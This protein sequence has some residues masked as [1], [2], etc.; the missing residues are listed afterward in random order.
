M[1]YKNAVL[2][3]DLTKNASR[4]KLFALA[5]IAVLAFGMLAAFAH[6]SLTPTV[7]LLPTGDGD[8]VTVNVTGD[9]SE[10]VELFYV[11]SGYGSQI[12]FLGDTNVNGI[13]SATL[14]SSADGIITGTPV[15][16][17]VGGINGTPSATTNWPVVST[18]LTGTITLSPTSMVVNVGQTATVGVTSGVSGSLYISNNSNP[19]VA[20]VSVSGSVVSVTGLA[21]GSTTVT[22][23]SLSSTS[24]CP[25]LYIRVQSAGTPTLSFSQSTLTVASG[26]TVPVTV[27]GGNGVYTILNN[28]NSG[29]I[30]A[31][32]AGS[33]VTIGTTAS[34]GTAAITVCSSDLTSCGII[35][36]TAG[37]T[38]SGVIT[39]SQQYPTLTIG[40]TTTVAVYGGSGSYYISSNSNPNIVGASVLNSVLTLTGLTSGSSAVSVCS[41]TGGCATLSATT[42]YTS[43]GGSLTLSQNTL[44]LLSG[45]TLSI[46]ISGGQAPYS[47]TT[48]STA[49]YQASISGNVLSVTGLSSGS[50]QMAVCSSAGGCTWLTLQINGSTVGTGGTLALSQ[51]SISLSAGQTS[52]ISISGTGG[53]YVS[54]VSTPTVAT[55]S[56]SGSLLQ[57]TGESYGSSTISVCQSGGACTTVYVSVGTSTTTTSSYGPAALLSF[58]TPIETIGLGQTTTVPIV[59]GSGIYYVAYSSNSGAVTASIAGN[60]LSLSGLQANS[61]DVVTVCSST[62][63]CGALPVAVGVVSTVGSTTTTGTTSVTT[64]TS[65]SSSD[66]YV[67]TQFLN[68]GSQGNEVVELQK[69][70][71]QLG[72]F[73]GNDTGYFGA[74][75]A[76]A[77]EAFQS[78]HGISAVGYVGPSTRAALNQ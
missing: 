77:V 73:S 43:S 58:G 63:S 29:I 30:F 61:L 49:M 74:L 10:A 23:C 26:Q 25:S 72:Y 78:A 52:S 38:S 50:T 51:T 35:N 11:K 68:V 17:A 54:N 67:F 21:F 20:N 70:L 42:S 2:S 34:S 47:L 59:G 18:S 27:S 76:Q 75:T 14:S 9:P 4:L 33:T 16:V 65:S 45:Q 69:R 13:L 39:F 41:S 3:L 6:A 36:V 15:H 60:T 1:P 64:T 22:I 44:S 62:N 66:G 24:N 31:S 46:T 53:Y 19:S 71:G 55:A 57:I 32:I 12:A 5:A 28:S 56:V 40:Q 8:T 48:P 37:L 7:Q